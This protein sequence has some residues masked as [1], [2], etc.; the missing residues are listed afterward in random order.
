[1]SL[2]SIR[3]DEA[4]LKRLGDRE[5]VR[6]WQ[7][8]DGDSLGLFHFATPPDIAADISNADDLRRFYRT[9]AYPSGLGLV[10]VD[11]IHVDGCRAARVIMKS[12]QAPSGMTYLGS[13]TLPFRDFSYVLKAQC[14]E[15]GV[16]GTRDAAV[17]NR[18]IAERR[19]RVAEDSGAIAGWMRDPYDPT[20]QAPLL[21][22]L[23]EAPEYDAMFA[24][25]P[26]SRL[27]RLLRHL[28]ASLRV[29]PRVRRAEPFQ[30]RSGPASIP[31]DVATGE[32]AIGAWLKKLEGRSQAE[33]E[34]LLGPPAERATWDLKGMK[35]PRFRYR[36]PSKAM[37][38]L[39]LANDHVVST[40][41]VLIPEG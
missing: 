14:E 36:L 10:E 34:A 37:L 9:V 6:L 33:V 20:V 11:P 16:T 12:K 26:L 38:D 19:V 2:D 25:H 30:Y 13:L 32:K 40:S 24:S 31:S 39:Y 23:A 21:A 22:N 17:L 1:M 35:L 18:A 5:G 7:T 29:D 28:E 41:Y 15:R 3:I 27:L 4:A 8:S